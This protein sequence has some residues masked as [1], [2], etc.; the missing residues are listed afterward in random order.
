MGRKNYI[1]A[2]LL[3]V[4]AV[5]IAVGVAQGQPGQVLTKAINVCLEC[6]GLG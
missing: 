2:G 3:L 6:V 5:L 1:L 4:A